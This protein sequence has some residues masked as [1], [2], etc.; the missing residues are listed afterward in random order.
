MVATCQ[1]FF[2]QFIYY[3]QCAV[4][5]LLLFIDYYGEAL[6]TIKFLC[7]GLSL[8]EPMHCKISKPM[9]AF[10]TIPRGC[11]GLLTPMGNCKIGLDFVAQDGR[12]Q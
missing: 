12:A 7:T 6:Q 4:R 3:L 5:I 8:K 11:R 1:L 9:G 10:H 2:Q